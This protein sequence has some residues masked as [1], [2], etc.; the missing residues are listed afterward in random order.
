MT[1]DSAQHRPST[2]H[3]ACGGRQPPP[4]PRQGRGLAIAALCLGIG[5]VV[6]SGI[7]VSVLVALPGVVLGIVAAVRARGPEHPGRTMA[8][9]GASLCGLVLFSATGRAFL[10]LTTLASAASG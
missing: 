3:P 10:A 1:A 9:V 7:V 4:T 8:I 2:G 6:V 5:A